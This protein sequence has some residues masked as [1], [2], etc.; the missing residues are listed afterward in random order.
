MSLVEGQWNHIAVAY[1]KVGETL[2]LA[3]YVNFEKSLTP[4][5]NDTLNQEPV[6]EKYIASGDD[7]NAFGNLDELLIFPEFLTDAQIAKLNQTNL[8]L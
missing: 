5:E 4:A 2:D 1:Q 8:E 3:L 7:R 6:I